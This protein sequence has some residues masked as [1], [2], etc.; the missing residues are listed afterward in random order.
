MT[1]STLIIPL[2][3]VEQ[4]AKKIAKNLVGGEILALTGELGS[5]KTTF[6]KA[7][8]KAL[9]VKQTIPSPTFVIMQEFKTGAPAKTVPGKKLILYHLDLYRTKNFSEVK[10]LGITQWWGHPETVTAIEWAEKIKSR[11]PKNTIYIQLQRDVH[12]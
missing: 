5:G 11:L 3:K 10:A 7:L 1:N 6:V 12:N 9:K 4:A 2:S 8:G